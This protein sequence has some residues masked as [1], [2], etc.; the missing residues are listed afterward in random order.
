MTVQR[1]LKWE[2]QELNEDAFPEFKEIPEI[3]DSR[4][5]NSGQYNQRCPSGNITMTCPN[6]RRMRRTLRF[7]ERKRN[8]QRNENQIG[9]RLFIQNNIWHNNIILRKNYFQIKISQQQNYHVMI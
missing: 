2:N 4:P 3:K 5:H 8:I 9:I 6:L 1:K 7:P